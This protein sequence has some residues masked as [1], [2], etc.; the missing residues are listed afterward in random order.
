MKL[1]AS[2]IEVKG[3]KSILKGS[4]V[5]AQPDGYGYGNGIGF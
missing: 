5:M 3:V 4:V 1:D 2:E